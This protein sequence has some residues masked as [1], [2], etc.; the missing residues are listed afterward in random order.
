MSSKRPAVSII[1]RFLPQYRVDFFCALRE[2]LEG[3]GIDLQLVYGKNRRSPKKDELDLDWATPVAN[4]EFKLGRHALYWQ[5][6]PEEV[7]STDLIILMQENKILSNYYILY[8][9]LK[10]RKKVALWGHGVN[11]QGNPNSLSTR[12]KKYYS[13]KV[14]W[15]FAYTEGVA[16]LVG[17]M[18]FPEDHIT[19][20]NNAIDTG[21]LAQAVAG[22]DQK[23]V[24]SLRREYS[25]GEGPIGL[26]CGGMY[27]EKR[28]DF[29]ISAVQQ[30]RARVPNFQ[31]MFLGEGPESY[32]L[33][34]FAKQ[35]SWVH[36]VGPKFGAARA[37][38]F[39]MADVFLM[40]GSL[41]LAILDCFA[42]E[43]PLVTTRYP[44]HGPEIEYLKNGFNGVITENNLDDYVSGVTNVLVSTPLQ[45]KIKEGCCDS[46]SI[47]TLENMV[48]NFRGGVLQAL[49]I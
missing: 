43:I 45:K 12:F 13:G 37:P 41:G 22:V 46:A 35:E 47:Y 32:K 42:S 24:E 17:E 29:L 31:M 49:N 6:V 28:I 38:F 20:L 14:D 7:F 26:F 8:N 1:Y 39:K 3:A 30:I 19:V 34:D 40:P 21:V 44:Y 2:S 15:W 10:N 27:K 16:R 48:S 25:V 9:A 11:F 4:R 18:G 33:K 5:P 23:Q 36:Y